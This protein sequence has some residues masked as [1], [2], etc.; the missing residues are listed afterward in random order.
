MTIGEVLFLIIL[1]LISGALIYGAVYNWLISLEYEREVGKYFEFADRASDAKTKADYFNQYI[2]ALE[3][4]GLTTGAS[5][6]FFQEQP[7]ALLEDNYKVA[8]SLQT[9]LN[10]VA[11]LNS[12]SFEYATHMQQITLQEFCW[13][14]EH[15]FW[16][17]YALKHGAWGSALSPYDVVNRCATKQSSSGSGLSAPLTYP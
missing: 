9:R 3:S 16:Q 1:L 11:T 2:S 17:G 13:F 14:P 10:S 15:A 12:T 5:S 8:Q 6:I 7:N 4:E